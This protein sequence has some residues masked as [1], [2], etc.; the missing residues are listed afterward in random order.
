MLPAIDLDD[1][2][3]LAAYKVGVIRPKRLL[4]GKLLSAETSVAKRQPQNPFGPRAA[5]PQRAG[6]AGRIKVR[7]SHA[8]SPPPRPSP[9]KRGGGVLDD[10]RAGS[11]M[12]ILVSTSG[13]VLPL[14]VRYLS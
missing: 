2:L 5:P 8:D 6:A 10:V 13:F 7:S 4:P 9:P 3:L 14:Q 11:A 1:E 12:A